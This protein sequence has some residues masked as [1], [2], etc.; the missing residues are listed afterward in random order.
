MDVEKKLNK[1]AKKFGSGNLVGIYTAIDC[2]F[3]TSV[4]ILA[5]SNKSFEFNTSISGTIKPVKSNLMSNADELGI[6]RVLVPIA[7]AS[8]M[9]D[10]E[11]LFSYYMSIWTNSALSSLTRRLGDLSGRQVCINF[12]EGDAFR[13][14]ENVAAF[15]LIYTVV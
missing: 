8:K 13:M 15:E 10:D 5:A 7:I 9:S 1:L 11:R 2:C 12:H 14:L 6:L 3:D 4:E